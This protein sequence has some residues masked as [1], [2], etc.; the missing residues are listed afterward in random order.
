MP[1]K[2]FDLIAIGGGTAGLV[3]A[4]GSAYLGA[5][6]ALIEKQRLGGDC[7]WT[8]CV[9][10]KALLA[11][12]RSA[13]EARKGERLGL[14]PLTVTPHFGEVIT[15]VR[16]ARALVAR[17]DEPDRIRARGI[18]VRFGPA[19]FTG[20]GTVEVE[21]VGTLRSKRIVLATGA[22]PAIPPIPGLG[23]AGYLTHETAFDQDT[24]PASIVILGGG[25]IGLE[26]A[27]AYRRLGAEVTVIERLVEA[28]PLE[29]PGG[30]GCRSPDARGGGSAVRVRRHGLGSRVGGRERP[31]A[32]R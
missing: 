12:A 28:L 13:E 31:G 1:T 16:G 19:R 25:P 26:F 18:D 14:P 8:G 4:S 10:S 29:D 11:A 32:R 2:E 23:E 21:G 27:Q 17:H 7:L 15:R 24:L 5:R 3:S 22:R 20:P 6:V 9:P 30:G